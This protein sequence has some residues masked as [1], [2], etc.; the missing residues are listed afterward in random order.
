MTFYNE[1]T[2]AETAAGEKVK[3]YN[4][5]LCSIADIYQLESA[6]ALGIKI[7]DKI[8]FAT[9]EILSLFINQGADIS[10]VSN[11]NTLKIPCACL[12]LKYYWME[13][14]KKKDDVASIKMDHYD[15][16]YKDKII[17]AGNTINSQETNVN[18]WGQTRIER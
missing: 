11:F 1:T 5:L 15:N 4:R 18:L 8:E 7:L 12:A 16:L 9:R 3:G 10:K 6:C 17:E 13:Q 14:V 2:A